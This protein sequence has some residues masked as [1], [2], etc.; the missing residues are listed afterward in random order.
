MK[1]ANAILIPLLFSLAAALVACAPLEFEEYPEE[2]GG[3]GPTATVTGDRLPTDAGDALPVETQL[4]LGT[5]LLEG[6]DLAVDADQAAVLLPLWQEWHDL[7]RDE[8]ASSEDREALLER[9]QS[10]MT[11][12]QIE[13]IAAMELT[14]EDLSAYMQ[15]HPSAYGGGFPGFD[16]AQTM[17]PEELATLQSVYRGHGG[18]FRGPES[19]L[20]H[21]LLDLLESKTESENAE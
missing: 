4:V 18:G 21:A 13:A 9:I 14:R 5:L 7:L 6:T 1:P 15:D 2:P 3:S 17:S 10:A 20:L 11:A 12:G 19:A 8:T 16:Q